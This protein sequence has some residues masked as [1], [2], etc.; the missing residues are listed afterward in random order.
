MNVLS[1]T[2][3]AMFGPVGATELLVI[4]GIALLL[5][6]ARKLPELAHAMGASINQ[7]KRGLDAGKEDEAKS[8]KI[9]G[10]DA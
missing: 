8:K 3:L 9:E 4:G 5:F 10:G 7:F 6:G 1:M 2:Q